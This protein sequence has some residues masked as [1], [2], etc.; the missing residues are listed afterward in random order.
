MALFAMVPRKTS[1][2]PITFLHNMNLNG[3]C[4]DLA[5]VNCC[6]AKVVLLTELD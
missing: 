4:K 6:F 3:L 2:E 5:P 1:T